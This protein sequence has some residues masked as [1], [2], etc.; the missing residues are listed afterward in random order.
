M[1]IEVVSMSIGAVIAVSADSVLSVVVEE[2]PPQATN[3]RAKPHTIT[4]A[5]SFF[6]EFRFYKFAAN[7]RVQAGFEGR[8]KKILTFRLLLPEI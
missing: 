8:R 2:P 4:S 7:I 6:I 5:I 1:S 3:A